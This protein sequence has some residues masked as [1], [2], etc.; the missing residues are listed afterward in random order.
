MEPVQNALHNVNTTIAGITTTYPGA[1]AVV[2]LSG[3]GNYRYQTATILPYKGN[4][5]KFAKPRHYDAIRDHL[6]KHHAAVL[7]IGMEADDEIG[8]AQYELAAAGKSPIIVSTD[9]DLNMIEG[10]H[11]NWVNKEEYSVDEH[12]A[13]RSF[14]GQLLTGDRVDNVPGIDGVGP[15]TA[16]EILADYRRPRGMLS[17]VRKAW[18]EAY[19]SG[20]PRHDGSIIGTDKALIEVGQ[21]LWIRRSKDEPL[22]HPTQVK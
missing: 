17:A 3:K 12:E 10:R 1:T 19:P 9:K 18:H 14:F 22:W 21:L 16:G 8:I 15:V 20:V 13:Y 11:Y 4:R 7:S 6:I 5:S 2:L